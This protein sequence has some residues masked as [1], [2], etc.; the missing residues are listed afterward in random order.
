MVFCLLAF[1]GF[2]RLGPVVEGRLARAM[3][4]LDAFLFTAG[5]AGF[6][7]RF[8]LA[9]ALVTLGDPL[10]RTV[11]VAC[12]LGDL[13][14]VFGLVTLLVRLPLELVPARF[15]LLKAGAVLFILSGALDISA[16]GVAG[17]GVWRSY[18]ALRP[19]GYSMVGLA[20]VYGAWD[21]IGTGRNATTNEVVDVSRLLVPRMVLPYL[22]LPVVG[23]LVLVDL[24]SVAGTAGVEAVTQSVAYASLVVGALL[25][26]QFVMFVQN[27]RLTAA[28]GELSRSLE[29]GVKERTAELAKTTERVRLLYEAATGISPQ[30][31]ASR[32][33]QGAH[34]L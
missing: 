27:S 26:R 2:L 24:L 22:S 1:V 23:A 8:V 7:W 17:T 28:L 19:L 9:P 15:P 3:S 11:V 6:G 12:S 18:E 32:P 30:I 25:A 21:S 4:V 13:L 16:F 20:A 31:F 10:I 14:L 5:V 33:S 34:L 29:S